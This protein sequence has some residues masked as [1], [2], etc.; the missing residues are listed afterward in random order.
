MNLIADV[1][2]AVF[3]QKGRVRFEAHFADGAVAVCKAPFEAY[4]V[5]NEELKRKLAEFVEFET[6]KTVTEIKLLQIMED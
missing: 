3:G 6:G 2:C 4:N 5:G 1:L